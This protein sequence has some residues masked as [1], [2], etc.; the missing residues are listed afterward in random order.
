MKL[1]H[2]VRR[3]ARNKN[4]FYIEPEWCSRR[5]FET[6]KFR[7]HIHDPCAGTGRILTEARLAGYRASGHDIN[8]RHPDVMARDFMTIDFNI[9]NIVCNPPFSIARKFTELAID[10]SIF[11]CALILP[12]VW[13]NGD[14]RSR[15]LETTPLY[16]ILLLTPRPSMPPG[17]V[18]MAGEAARNGTQD[19][20]WFIWS[21]G[22]T[23]PAQIG[24]LRRDGSPAMKQA[25]GR[26][27]TLS[28]S[29]SGPASLQGLSL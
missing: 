21:R 6:E 13:L 5:L 11:K 1:V 29:A 23:G 12:T 28:D 2:S 10:C 20:A 4:D 22:H 16:K 24:W 18:V 7:G 27:P 19:F 3:W 8:P 17:E 9:D 15:W 25:D 26:G 14:K